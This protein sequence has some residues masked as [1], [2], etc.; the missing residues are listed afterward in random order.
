[1]GL[2]EFFATVGSIL[3]MYVCPRLALNY[4]LILADSSG[5]F[6]NQFSLFCGIITVVFDKN[7]ERTL[8]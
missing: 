3:T 7:A 4:G 5:I 8:I 2:N 1:M 6:F